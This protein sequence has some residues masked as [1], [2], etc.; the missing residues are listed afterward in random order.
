MLRNSSVVYF[1]ISIL[2]SVTSMAGVF[3][4]P[5]LYE[6]VSQWHGFK[7][8]SFRVKLCRITS[9]GALKEYSEKKIRIYFN[10]DSDFVKENIEIK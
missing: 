3:K 2:L 9:N 8:S 10:E 6:K 5:M 1:F 7:G 4:D